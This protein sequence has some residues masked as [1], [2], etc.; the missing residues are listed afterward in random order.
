MWLTEGHF[1]VCC[2]SSEEKWKPE[3]WHIK[4]GRTRL[5]G[6]M[7]LKEESQQILKLQSA[8]VLLILRFVAASGRPPSKWAIISVRRRWKLRSKLIL[9]LTI[10]QTSACE[11]AGNLKNHSFCSK[12]GWAHILHPGGKKIC[13]I[14]SQD[15]LLSLR[16]FLEAETRS[17]ESN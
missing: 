11:L 5:L 14:F 16:I 4:E 6:V 8:P 1:D 9:L 10:S 7:Q 2:A 15:E 17:P 3:R 13:L 12:G